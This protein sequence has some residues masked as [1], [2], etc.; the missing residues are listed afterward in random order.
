VTEEVGKTGHVVSRIRG[1]DKAGEVTIPIRGGHEVYLAYADEPIETSTP[2][3]VVGNR[4]GRCLEVVPW[5][6]FV[7]N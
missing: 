5:T 7:Q 2:I 3:L 6:G 1:G 4:G